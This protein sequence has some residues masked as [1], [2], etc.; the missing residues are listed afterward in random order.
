MKGLLAAALL[1]LL[2]GPATAYGQAP[3]P[4]PAQDSGL[5]SP[6]CREFLM[7]RVWPNLERSQYFSPET[8]Q[9]TYWPL[10]A[11]PFATTQ[12]P[13]PFPT[14]Y[15]QPGPAGGYYAYPPNL[16]GPLV[17]PPLTSANVLGLL[18]AGGAVRPP[19]QNLDPQVVLGLANLQSAEAGRILAL[20]KQPALYQVSA[21]G[22]ESAYALEANAW[23]LYATLLGVCRIPRGTLPADG[24]AGIGPA[25]AIEQATTAQPPAAPR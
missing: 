14:P 20:W 1:V 25:L 24:Q 21:A 15:R 5:A 18:T 19:V 23:M 22:A 16:P 12:V 13:V 17:Q 3:P 2:S 10:L 6:R 4:A 7:D 8:Y 11:A 9:T